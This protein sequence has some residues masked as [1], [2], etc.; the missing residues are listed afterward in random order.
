MINKYIRFVVA[1]A[2]VVVIVLLA[3]GNAVWAGPKSIGEAAV[4]L[5]QNEPSAPL[6]EPGRG[7]VNPPPAEF[8]GCGDGR[9]SIGGV[10][11]LETKDLK[12]GYCIKALLWDPNFKTTLIP[13][14]TGI[15]LAH[16]LFLRVYYEGKLVYDVPAG[17]GTVESC[18]AIPPDKQAQIYFY[19]YYGVEFQ[20]RTE[21]PLAWDLL[22]TQ[23]DETNKTACAFTQTSGVYAL[24]GK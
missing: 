16:M 17:D 20:K 2:L 9:Y 7:S 23:V 10:V 18:Y 15:P 13:E 14:D 11:I 6:S 1:A 21:P 24:V 5:E 3:G 4:A 8:Y 22:P 12:P 19:D